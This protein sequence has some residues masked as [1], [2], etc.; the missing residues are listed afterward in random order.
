MTTDREERLLDAIGGIDD[1]LITAAEK[2]LARPKPKAWLGVAAALLVAVAG[3]AYFLQPN[4]EIVPLPAIGCAEAQHTEKV[5]ANTTPPPLAAPQENFTLTRSVGNVKVQ[6]ADDLNISDLPASTACLA[7][8]TEDEIFHQRDTD[9]FRGIIREIR[10]IEISL[11]GTKVYQAIAY[12]EVGYVYRGACQAGDVVSVLLSGA[13]GRDVQVSTAGGIASAM[14]EGMTGIFMPMAH[15]AETLMEAGEAK[16]YLQEVAS[17][18]FL[19][20]ERYAF[21]DTENGLTFAREAFGLIKNAES[22]DEAEAYVT[23]MLTPRTPDLPLLR[24]DS[25][26]MGAGFAAH[27]MYDA[28]ELIDG[29]PWSKDWTPESLPVYANKAQAALRGGYYITSGLSVSDMTALAEETARRFGLAVL[30]IETHP[31]DAQLESMRRKLQREGMPEDGIPYGFS[32]MADC[33]L[34]SITVDPNGDTFIDYKTEIPLPAAYR[35]KAAFTMEDAQALADYFLE[36]YREALGYQSPAANAF[37]NYTFA[38]ERFFTYEIF[39]AA[40]SSVERLLRFHFEKTA[41]HTNQRGYLSSIRLTRMDL[42]EKLG[43][44]P[45]ITEAEAKALLLAGHYLTTVP[46]EYGAPIEEAVAGV[47]LYYRAA[48]YY[49]EIMPFYQFYV[50]LPEIY[51]GGKAEGLHTYGIFEVPALQAEYLMGFP[52]AGEI[53]FN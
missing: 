33:D 43:D 18:F 29:N 14:R 50:L 44:Y 32:V 17:H 27:M 10:N 1:A 22:L 31:T 20:G 4:R 47:T 40:G 12:I 6:Y 48:P 2:G 25:Y 42:S 46:E 19:D 39:E 5:A 15:D 49:R 35:D 9:I 53:R 26:A 8:L 38:G 52:S 51:E 13:I 41:F 21:L 16:L 11:N 30:S 3:G 7:F 34:A 36:E 24:L 23:A 28:A 37:G 45:A